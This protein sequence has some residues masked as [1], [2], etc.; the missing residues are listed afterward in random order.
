M[1]IKYTNAIKA[2]VLLFC[3]GIAISPASAWDGVVTEKVN[4]I[5]FVPSTGGQS[6]R[7][8]LVG[9]PIICTGG[10]SWGYIDASAGNYEAIAS[11][12][13]LSYSTGKTVTVYTT[14][15][16]SDYCEIGYLVLRPSG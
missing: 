4:R 10:P 9:D 12:L 14:K 6:L 2:A 15:D 3:V 11:A 1:M 7:V 5:D 16:A 13:M 8:Y